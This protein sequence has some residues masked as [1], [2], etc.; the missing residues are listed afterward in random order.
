MKIINI[1]PVW[2]SYNP[3]RVIHEGMTVTFS[4]MQLAAFMG[5]SEVY[6]L[7]VDCNYPTVKTE[8]GETVVDRTAQTHFIKDY[9]DKN[10]KIYQPDTKTSMEAYKSAQEY[11]ESHEIKFFN[12]T[13][14]GALEAFPRVDFDEVMQNWFHKKEGNN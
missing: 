3:H 2:F 6:L 12:A 1:H 7:G 10:E 13:R 14:G 8:A 4:I 11:A 9:W 5:F